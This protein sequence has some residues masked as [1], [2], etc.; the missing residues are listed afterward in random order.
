MMMYILMFLA[1]IVL[2]HKYIDRP[3]VFKIPGGSF[4]MWT[5]TILG[6]FGCIITIVIGFFP[7]DALDF[8]S[9]GEYALLIALGNVVVLAPLSIF[10]LYKKLSRKKSH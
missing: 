10:F 9:K 1:A 2:H 6:L 4:G 8:H 7:P 3:K 5:T